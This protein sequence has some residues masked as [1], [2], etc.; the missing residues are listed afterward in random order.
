MDI[1]E[2]KSLVTKNPVLAGRILL[3][4]PKSLAQVTLIS[5]EDVDQKYNDFCSTLG[6]KR[7]VSLVVLDD[8][9]MADM[10]G[11]YH[12][13]SHAIFLPKSVYEGFQKG[14]SLNEYFV[15]HELGHASMSR[16]HLLQWAAV[17]GAGHVG[18]AAAR[19]AAEFAVN[20]S[21]MIPKEKK[22]VPQSILPFTAQL[23]GTATCAFRSFDLLMRY[24]EFAADEK[25]T[26]NKPAHEIILALGEGLEDAFR[27]KFGE[28]ELTSL[29]Q[30]FEQAIYDKKGIDVK[31]FNE[32]QQHLLWVVGLAEML[33]SQMS[34]RRMVMGK[35]YPS[36]SER[37]QRLAPQV[38]DKFMRH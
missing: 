20:D 34:L 27:K 19:K 24:E 13:L 8:S 3:F 7:N 33:D 37:I 5:P 29:R 14:V 35:L 38:E 36:H 23:V 11:G 26:K 15:A 2:L 22:S 18:G 17:L 10:G 4:G 30:R 1:Q 12:L 25:A 9:L 32:D 21:P 31:T 6:L 28:D 16:R